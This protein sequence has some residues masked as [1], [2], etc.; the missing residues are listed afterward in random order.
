MLKEA[1]MSDIQMSRCG[2]MRGSMILKML[3]V[4][5]VA[6]SLGLSAACTARYSQTLS[7][8]IPNQAGTPVST[9]STGLSVFAIAF[10]EPKPAHEQ[11]QQLLGGCSSLNKVQVDYREKVFLV[12]GIPEISVDAVCV[13]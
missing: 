8:P 1:S 7:G 13:K 2:A 9:S 6:L 5:C 4:A 10:T 12:V 11:V 3:L